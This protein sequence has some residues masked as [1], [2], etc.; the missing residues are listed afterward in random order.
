M[1]DDLEQTY[2]LQIYKINVG[3]IF[4]CNQV[5]V[6]SINMVGNLL[7]TVF[8]H[9]NSIVKPS[10][11]ATFVSQANEKFGTN[12]GFR[13]L[14]H[15]LI[16]SSLPEVQCYIL[17]GRINADIEEWVSIQW[18]KIVLGCVSEEK[19]DLDDPL[20]CTIMDSELASRQEL[21]DLHLSVTSNKIQATLLCGDTSSGKSHVIEQL[22][23]HY[24]VAYNTSLDKRQWVVA[25]NLLS[26][27]F[28]PLF[29]NMNY[30]GAYD[31]DRVL[32]RGI[33]ESTMKSF[34]SSLSI[35]IL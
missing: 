30:Y 12:L 32:E 31:V 16:H 34:Y 14:K 15:L 5:P 28:T 6:P 23:L 35:A 8:H 10:S 29:S 13:A 19:W 11:V 2:A 25:L 4:S 22:I 33:I 20:A 1:H 17:G 3:G 27:Q 18:Q 24:N 21:L 7:E 26:T 9:E